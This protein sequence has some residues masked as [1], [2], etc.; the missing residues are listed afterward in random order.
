MK[1]KLVVISFTN[2]KVE[3]FVYLTYEFHENYV[4]FTSPNG[5]IRYV[6]L[7]NCHWIDTEGCQNE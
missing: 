5:K 1:S 6:M 2:G 4:A 3:A 7:R